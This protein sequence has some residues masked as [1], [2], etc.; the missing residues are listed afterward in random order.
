MP[1]FCFS[2]VLSSSAAEAPFC[3]IFADEF[4]IHKL[5]VC[6]FFP[7]FGQVLGSQ[8]ILR[9]CGGKYP[10]FFFGGW[11]PVFCFS[12]VLSSSAAEAPFCEIFADEFLIHK[13]FV[14]SFFP[15]F[16]QV[17]GSQAI[18]RSCGGKYPFSFFGGWMFCLLLFSRFV[19]IRR[20]SSI[21]RNLCR[22]ILD[23]QAI[24]VLF[25]FGVRTSPRIASDPAE[26]RRKISLLLF[27]RMDVLCVFY[28]NS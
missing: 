18:L 13:L 3:E 1:V 10:F 4:L 6:S 23:S 16:G 28:E 24:C 26:L 12:L 22:R 21:L 20:G 27:W 25:F 15:A 17:L 11:M 7:A 9:S 5:F 2:L 19:F 8:A 14:C